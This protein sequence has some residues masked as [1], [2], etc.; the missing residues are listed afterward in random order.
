MYLENIHNFRTIAIIGIVG[1]HSLHNFYWG[2]R[3]ILFE[4]FD[5]LFNESSIWFFFIAGYLFQYLS[6]KFNARDYYV[7]KLKNVIAPYL[8]LSIPALI[9]SL[10]FVDQEM[11]AGFSDKHV[12]EQIFLFLIT[13]KHLAPFWFV[14]TISII[15][16]FAPMLIRA[17]RARWPYYALPILLVMSAFLGR[18]GFLT[19]TQIGGYFSPISKAIYLFP[20]YFFGMFCSQYRD[21]IAPKVAAWHWPLLILAALAYWAG[22]IEPDASVK[23]IFIFKVI[24]ALLLVY[25]L[26]LLGKDLLARISYVGTASFGI[27]FVHGYFLQAVKLGKEFV[28]G[29]EVFEI[30]VFFLIVFIIFITAISCLSLWIAQKVLGERSRLVVGV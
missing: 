16:L 20:V 21:A 23:Y 29:S 7:T 11:P 19:I 14:P 12:I 3:K 28:T 25:Y 5:T 8:I 18:D 24:T 22:V 26:D 27:F 17:D 1:A 30:N 2:E 6:K 10:T 4:V 9:A 15:Y 13:G